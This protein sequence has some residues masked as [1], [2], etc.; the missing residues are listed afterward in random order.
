MHESK[1]STLAF[2][3]ILYLISDEKV[4]ELEDKTEHLK[5]ERNV[6]V[7]ELKEKIVRNKQEEKEL[8]EKLKK[9]EAK[10]KEHEAEIASKGDECKAADKVDFG[11]NVGRLNYVLGDSFV[12]VWRNLVNQ[13]IPS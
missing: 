7:A 4:K 11:F 8:R 10:N 9:L 6:E 13:I 12:E 3:P 1:V 5:K 2:P